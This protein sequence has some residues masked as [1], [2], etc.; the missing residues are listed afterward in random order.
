[1][2]TA[3]IAGRQRSAGALV[4]AGCA[5]ASAL[6]VLLVYSPLALVAV[7][8]LLF[9]VVILPFF[10]RVGFYLAYPIFFFLPLERLRIT[11]LP[12]LS[13]PLNF[14]VIT[15]AVVGIAHWSLRPRPLPAS[16]LYV[17][18]LLAALVLIVNIGLRNAAVGAVRLSSLL[19]GMWPFAL[20]ILLVQTPR[21]AGR[22][23]RVSL[24]CVAAFA[25]IW[26]P[27]LLLVG[28]QTEGDAA[29][30]LSRRVSIE[31]AGGSLSLNYLLVLAFAT[32][33]PVF[34]AVAW[35]RD[36][37]RRLRMLS[38]TAGVF[39]LIALITSGYAA[40]P[41]GA[42]VGAALVP[43]IAV[44]GDH[45]ERTPSA[46]LRVAAVWLVVA[47]LVIGFFLVTSQGRLLVARVLNPEDDFS[48]AFRLYAAHQ[49][50][51]AFLANPLIGWG[52]FNEPTYRAGYLL[53]GHTTYV[54]AAY[55]FGLLFLI[56][57][58][59][60]LVEMVRLPLGLVRRA[61]R[62]LDRAVVAGFTGSLAVVLVLGL[63]TEVFD[64]VIP[65]SL[66]WLFLGLAT[67][68]RGWLE[69]DPNAV[70]VE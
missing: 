55:E 14:L 69:R 53:G 58:L 43:L 9:G 22:I 33:V 47:L 65:L 30:A 44:L 32:A 6:G 51:L 8:V 18:V 46:V 59:W 25:A 21:Q 50:V 16:R 35:Y 62:S 38:G 40:A 27:L 5:A 26:I 45:R 70:L 29:R 63:V 2:S 28:R 19:L 12:V 36:N 57:F 1:M 37:P 41:L 17:P 49:G 7:G 60:L 31:L 42:V 24:G 15:S 23:L 10:P 39:V 13:S 52:P 56:P 66:V 54:K 20:A 64:G 3:T 34:L 61:R 4:I 11:D 68:W 48:G 67:V